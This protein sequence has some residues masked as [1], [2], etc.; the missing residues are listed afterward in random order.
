MFSSKAIPIHDNSI[1]EFINAR[2]IHLNKI[3]APQVFVKQHREWIK[4]TTFRLVGLDS[5]KYGYVTAGV[6]EAFNEVYRERCYVLNGEYSYHKDIGIPI[7]NYKDIPFGS[8]LIISYP[9]AATG[10][11]H[12]DWNDIIQHCITW[13]ID[14]FVDACLAGVSLGKLDLTHSCITHVA[15]SFSKAFNTGHIR[16]GVV[17]TTE[18]YSSPASVT[19][20]HFYLNH[21]S[22][23]LHLDLMNKFT[24]D[25][26][27]QKY[28]I[29]QIKLCE[30]HNLT[31]S[32]CVLFG[33]DNNKRNCLSRLLETLQSYHSQQ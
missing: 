4:N 33:L 15:F 19:N 14:V 1:K 13:G 18:P 7:S 6:T 12:E 28:R 2:E 25:W 10:N 30:E 32:D 20:K 17:Y 11:P 31:Q 5:F 8:R 9:F 27:F 24:S 29:N 22:M 21:S 23:L 3:Y 16:C 26:I